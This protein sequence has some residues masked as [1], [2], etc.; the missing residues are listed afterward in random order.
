MQIWQRHGSFKKRR[1]H[2]RWWLAEN[3][4]WNRRSR[5]PRISAEQPLQHAA[6]WHW[7]PRQD[8]EP[9]RVSTLAVSRLQRP[10]TC[11]VGDWRSQQSD[12]TMICGCGRC[13]KALEL[14]GTILHEECYLQH[15]SGTNSWLNALRMRAVW[16]KKLGC[17]PA[18]KNK[19]KNRDCVAAQRSLRSLPFWHCWTVLQQ[20]V[21]RFEHD[22]QIYCFKDMPIYLNLHALTFLCLQQTAKLALWGL[23]RIQIPPALTLPYLTKLLECL[24]PYL[25]LS[26]T[27]SR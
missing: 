24:V 12:Y 4:E 14:L 13:H 17:S 18:W 7:C 22:F 15:C 3:P 9:G 10:N 23:S 27:P 2:H 16:S 25:A 11:Y 20:P 6:N 8:A 1:S 26:N 5:S 21:T 19:G